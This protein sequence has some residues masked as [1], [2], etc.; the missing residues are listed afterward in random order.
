MKAICK[1]IYKREENTK[2]EIIVWEQEDGATTYQFHAY[3]LY[4]KEKEQPQPSSIKLKEYKDKILWVS[5]YYLGEVSVNALLFATQ[6]KEEF[7]GKNV[8]L[9]QVN[10]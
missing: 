4:P 8:K 9:K 6:N 7:R 10:K 3:W 1:F 2:N 5:E